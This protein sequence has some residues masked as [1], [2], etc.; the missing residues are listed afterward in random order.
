MIIQSDV[1]KIGILLPTVGK[2]TRY[3]SRNGISTPQKPQR[4][5]P[6]HCLQKGLKSIQ[7]INQ[8]FSSL[9]GKAATDEI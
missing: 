1:T 3:K 4:Y 2:V 6:F 9:W 7:N 8:R 5:L